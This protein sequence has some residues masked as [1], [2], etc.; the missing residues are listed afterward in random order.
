VRNILNEP[1]VVLLGAS[2]FTFESYS[3]LLAYGEQIMLAMQESEALIDLRPSSAEVH[4]QAIAT[5]CRLLAEVLDAQERWLAEHD[6]NLAAEEA[7]L[8]REIQILNIPARKEE[9]EED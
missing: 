3:E 6:A 2:P 7:S 5:N 9:M 4:W 8:R 1:K